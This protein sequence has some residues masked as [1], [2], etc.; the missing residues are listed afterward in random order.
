MKASEFLMEQVKFRVAEL[1]A[2]G[3]GEHDEGLDV[4][5]YLSENVLEVEHLYNQDGDYKG[6]ILTLTVGGPHVEVDT[7]RGQVVGR[8]WGESCALPYDCPDLD[9]AAEELGRMAIE[10]AR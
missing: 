6:S 2:L 1:K 9:T 4:W 10:N 7:T 8:D 5:D 3:M